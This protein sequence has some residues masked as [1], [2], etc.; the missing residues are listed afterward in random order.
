MKSVYSAVQPG[1]L[2]KFMCF[3]FIWEQTTTFATYNIKWLVF[4]TQMKSVYSAVRT[5]SLNKFMCFVFIWEQTAICATYTINWLVFYNRDEKCLQ[6]GTDWAFKWSSLRFVCKGL[7]YE[8]IKWH[9]ERIL[10]VC[11]KEVGLVAIKT[12]TWSFYWSLILCTSSSHFFTAQHN[13]LLLQY[14]VPFIVNC[15]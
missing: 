3:V 7:M 11:L 5:G 1:S 8:I 13:S 15:N 2:N 6:R 10:T 4:I 14:P 12:R 9:F